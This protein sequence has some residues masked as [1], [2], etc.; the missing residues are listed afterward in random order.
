M[1]LI[2]RIEISGHET[3]LRYDPSDQTVD[4]VVEDNYYNMPW[5]E[6]EALIHGFAHMAEQA[7]I[8]YKKNEAE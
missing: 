2:R 5:D 6:W 7:D 8:D 1:N 4:L 3:A